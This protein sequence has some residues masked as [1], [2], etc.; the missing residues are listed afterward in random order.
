MTSSSE[1]SSTSSVL[2]TDDDFETRDHHDALSACS[3][4]DA[5]YSPAVDRLQG[6]SL[7]QKLTRLGVDLA[8]IRYNNITIEDQLKATTSVIHKLEILLPNVSYGPDYIWLMQNHTSL[9]QARQHLEN[10]NR[11]QQWI[12]HHTECLGRNTS[13][14][15]INNVQQAFF[16]FESREGDI[17]MEF[18]RIITGRS[19]LDFVIDALWTVLAHLDRFRH[20]LHHQLHVD[21]VHSLEMKF[22]SQ[23]NQITRSM[24]NIKVNACLDNEEWAIFQKLD[25]TVKVSYQ[26][27]RDYSTDRELTLQMTARHINI[28]T[29]VN[30][31]TAARHVAH[32]QTEQKYTMIRLTEQANQLEQEDDCINQ[33]LS[34]A[35]HYDHDTI[36]TLMTQTSPIQHQIAEFVQNKTSV[37]NILPATSVEKLRILDNR[38]NQTLIKSQSAIE[39]QTAIQQTAK[40]A[41][42]LR[43]WVKAR[44]SAVDRLHIHIRCMFTEADCLASQKLLE[45]QQ[46][47]LN[48]FKNTRLKHVTE[49]ID[50]LSLSS[51]DDLQ[52]LKADMTRMNDELS[53]LEILLDQQKVELELIDKRRRWDISYKAAC[54]WIHQMMETIREFAMEKAQCKAPVRLILGLQ[55]TFSSMQQ[56]VSSYSHSEIISVTDAARS[57]IKQIADRDATV[58]TLIRQRRYALEQ[59]VASLNQLLGFTQAL[60]DQRAAVA[61][62]LASVSKAEV[63]GSHVLFEL[64]SPLKIPPSI[65]ASF[66]ALISYFD[67]Y[68]SVAWDSYQAIDY[69]RW[70][71]HA[72]V[73]KKDDS[74]VNELQSYLLE[75]Y[76]RLLDLSQSLNRTQT[77]HAQHLQAETARCSADIR[78]LLDRLERA[79]E[80][81]QA[82]DQKL[83]N[84]SYLLSNDELQNMLDH[85]NADHELTGYELNDL[86]ARLISVEYTGPESMGQLQEN[87]NQSS[88]LISDH[89]E[90]LAAYATRV[91]WTK[92][93]IE[94]DHAL[95]CLIGQ[96]T[97]WE[98]RYHAILF[99]ADAV[100]EEAVASLSE[101]LLTMEQLLEEIAGQIQQISEMF[102]SMESAYRRVAYGLPLNAVQGQQHMVS[103]FQNLQGNVSR[104]GAGIAFVKDRTHLECSLGKL[105]DLCGITLRKLEDFIRDR[106]RWQ[107]STGISHD[108]VQDMLRLYLDIL[109]NETLSQKRMAAQHEEA[110]LAL[111]AAVDP[112]Q[113]PLTYAFRRKAELEAFMTKV[114]QQI[115][116]ADKVLNQRDNVIEWMKQ[117]LPLETTGQNHKEAFATCSKLEKKERIRSYR[118]ELDLL[119]S[120]ADTLPYPVREDRRQDITANRAIA[121]AAK[122]QIDRLTDLLTTLR[123][124][125][126]KSKSVSEDRQRSRKVSLPTH[127][128][129]G[130]S[131]LSKY[132]INSTKSSPIMRRT[133]SSMLP[134]VP[135][136]ARPNAY[137]AD[138]KNDLDMEI[139]RIVN[140][141]PYKVKLEMIPGEV[142]RYLFGGKLVY[143]RILPSRMVMVRVGGGWTELSQFLRDHA[144]LDHG[145][146]KKSMCWDSETAIVG[147]IE[148]GFIDTR[149]RSETGRSRSGS[150]S[151]SSS[152]KY[153]AGYKDGDHYIAVDNN[154]NQLAFSMTPAT[155]V[156]DMCTKR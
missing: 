47:L 58:T 34:S 123:R 140:K 139:G 25:N 126:R 51:S 150:I 121:T 17:L 16:D 120:G 37:E 99:G 72:F 114:D 104:S 78:H 4:G 15:E 10:A 94:T 137:V 89:V 113:F 105:L 12:D 55:D 52:L 33:T 133:S 109:Q 124:S 75:Q 56:S 13:H 107:P 53:R 118:Q 62:Y 135:P 79:T 29:A 45:S 144:L 71:Q 154:G 103:S 77:M 70:P 100:T 128:P 136:C 11:L 87:A 32:H 88:L 149:S 64:Q 1:N 147:S 42:R 35:A 31:I 46:L 74:A 90:K 73:M 125:E 146:V 119:I 38:M 145:F 69:P 44:I 26:E 98:K 61:E 106:A 153:K 143:C 39:R 127:K 152:T 49:S 101:D 83:S 141:V 151:T 81:I 97:A 43:K 93:Q 76:H 116:F 112:E 14:V 30:E 20:Q 102:A 86:L 131:L 156:N 48:L 91:R 28:T 40:D 115:A 122:E 80:R 8:R 65:L 148:E 96:W 27:I 67:R 57:L 24:E 92:H 84:P 66:E 82:E 19:T 130:F 117:A 129:A 5:S 54:Q 134:P 6:S 108:N 21:H 95:Q 110:L 60:L 22:D 23:A 18:R 155:I 3:Q 59:D 111:Q 142:G 138:P 63:F 85:C 2:D 50:K 7:S 132:Q 68:L 41:L 36:Q 9:T